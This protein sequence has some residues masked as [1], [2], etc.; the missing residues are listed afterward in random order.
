MRR[1]T[2]VTGAFTLLAAGAVAGAT[3]A[4]AGEGAQVLRPQC[5]FTADHFPGVDVEILSTRCTVVIT[6]DGPVNAHFTAQVPD[7]YTV[8]P[9]VY[10]S[11]GDPCRAT[12][13]P[14]GRIINV[15]HFR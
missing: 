3:P 4:S 2:L 8:A 11:A 6:R 5:G 7:G 12:V 9:G 15:C 13:T 1:S 14:N 10:A